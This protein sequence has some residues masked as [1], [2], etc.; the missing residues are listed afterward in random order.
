M[1]TL[2]C[3]ESALRNTV[4]YCIWGTGEDKQRKLV[5]HWVSMG[6]NKNLKFL[7]CGAGPAGF[8]ASPLLHKHPEP[9]AYLVSVAVALSLT[10]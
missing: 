4:G 9:L 5:E 10:Q 6:K 8:L 3:A 7:L 1:L 2:F